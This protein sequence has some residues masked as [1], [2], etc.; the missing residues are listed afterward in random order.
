[1]CKG[2]ALGDSGRAERAA[3][4]SGEPD[5]PAGAGS[6]GEPA[7]GDGGRPDTIEPEDQSPVPDTSTTPS[8]LPV[9]VPQTNLAEP[10]RTDEPVVAEEPEEQDDPG[11]SPAEIQR[12]MGSYQRGTRRGRSDAAQAAAGRP[13]ERDDTDSGTNAAEGEED[14]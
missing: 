6:P 14:Q 4:P 11:R 9:R 5:I 3:A 12:I 7:A 8:G 1:M 13:D 2:Q 10:L